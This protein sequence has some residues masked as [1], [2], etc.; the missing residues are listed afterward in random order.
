M[1]R[2]MVAVASVRERRRFRSLCRRLDI[3][4]AYLAVKQPLWERLT[5][6]DYDLVI[7][8]GEILPAQPEALIGAI[9]SLPEQPEV[10]VLCSDEDAEERARLLAAGCLAV[11]WQ[12][13]ADATLS[14]TI[15]T[16]LD[17]R[18]ESARSLVESAE[19]EKHASLDEYVYASPAMQEF[20]LVARRVAPTSSTLL[21]LGETGVGKEW[22]ARAIHAGGPRAA[23]PFVAVNCG[24][25]P[26]GLLES[27]L[28]GHEQGAFTGATRS[29][30]GYF[31]LA[32]GGTLFLD[33]IADLPTHVQVKLL[34]VLEQNQLM[35]V[36]GER[37]VHTDVRVMAATNR[38]PATEIK[39]GRFRLD[40]YYRL[41]VVA[42]S[43]P[44]LR[45]R[46][47]DIPAIVDIY[48]KRFSDGLRKPVTGI[49]QRAMDAMVAY[50]WPGNV[51]ELMNVMERALLLSSGTEVDLPDLPLDVLGQVLAADEALGAVTGYD[52]PLPVRM[53]RSFA[54][55]R[56]QL[57]HR[58]ERE[59]VVAALGATHGRVGES[60]QRAGIDVR[61]LYG[62]M[63]KHG[64]RKEMFKKTAAS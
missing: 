28:F 10:V 39:A 44:P 36:G 1:L 41:A 49:T 7:V 33:E 58:F 26:E 23:G 22:L 12:G 38:D 14:Q 9:R 50:P 8:S 45:E 3:E 43:L 53:D 31:E 34:R 19:H 6:E 20:M 27:E 57:L 63:R 15:Q 55:A 42:L 25:L 2:V 18:R 29:R 48:L 21:I 52:A 56:Q 62:L 16:L 32:H 4:P 24:A 60:A 40:L 47:E 37:P 54:E 5:H 59:Y 11:L 64:L 35:R 30:K 13:L 46:R 17:R 61:S 51:R